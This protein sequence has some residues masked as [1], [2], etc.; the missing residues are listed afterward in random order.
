MTIVGVI[1]QKPLASCCTVGEHSNLKLEIV[2][3]L[4]AGSGAREEI[5]AEKELFTDKSRPRSNLCR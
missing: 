3:V 4:F 5:E 2:V 1:R